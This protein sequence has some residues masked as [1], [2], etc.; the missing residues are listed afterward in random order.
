[1]IVTGPSQGTETSIATGLAMGDIVVTDGVDKLQPGA[2][3][4]Y[5]GAKT[6]EASPKGGKPE[7]Q[8]APGGKRGDRPV[9]EKGK[10]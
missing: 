2:K 6:A 9:A 3:I 1:M 4:S 5:R 10:A 7:G 8:Q